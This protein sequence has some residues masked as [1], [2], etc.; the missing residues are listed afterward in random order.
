MSVPR[1]DAAFCRARV[2][3]ECA[4]VFLPD[5]EVEYLEEDEEL[6]HDPAFDRD[7]NTTVCMACYAALTPASPSG[8]GLLHELDATAEALRRRGLVVVDDSIKRDLQWYRE[9]WTVLPQQGAPAAAEPPA[10]L[11]TEDFAYFFITED[12]TRIKIGHSVD[13]TDRR[14]DLQ[15]GSPEELEILHVTTGGEKVE[16]QWQ[17]RFAHLRIGAGEEWFRADRELL[18]AIERDREANPKEAERMLRVAEERRGRD[19]ARRELRKAG[20][21]GPYH[22]AQLRIGAAA[23]KW[24]SMTRRARYFVLPWKDPKEHC[25]VVSFGKLLPPNDDDPAEEQLR[26]RGKVPAWTHSII[27]PKGE[28]GHVPLEHLTLIRDLDF[29]RAAAKDFDYTIPDLIADHM[30]DGLD[31]SLVHH[32]LLEW[33]R[34]GF[35]FDPERERARLPPPWS[36]SGE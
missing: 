25:A 4:L 26:A 30:R 32:K 18:D 13:P 29:E 24:R 14:G 34:K 35:A 17:R 19:R 21:E 2:T 33:W 9:N 23:C 16:K 8:Q 28:Y 3:W 20:Y 31:R 10:D 7:T 27:F 22:P 15:T 6:R 11:G 12:H 5:D 1:S 36:E